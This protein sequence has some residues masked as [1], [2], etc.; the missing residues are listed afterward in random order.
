MNCVRPMNA[1]RNIYMHREGRQPIHTAIISLW[2]N[3]TR[4]N[5]AT[6]TRPQLKRQSTLTRPSMNANHTNKAPH[7]PNNNENALMRVWRS[8]NKA[9]TARPLLVKGTVACVIF[10]SSDVV[11][12]RYFTFTAD[13]SISSKKKKTA[14]N[15]AIDIDYK[16]A[17]SGAAFGWVGTVWLHYW[18]NFLE[19]VIQ[20]R[21]PVGRHRLANTLTKV[22]IDQSLAAPLY[23]YTYFFLTNFLQGISS[24]SSNGDMKNE[25]AHENDHILAMDLSTHNTDE[26]ENENATSTHNIPLSVYE[27]HRIA[28]EKLWPTMFVHWSVWPPVHVLNF[29]FNPIQHRILVQNISLVGWSGYLSHRNNTPTPSTESTTVTLSATLEKRPTAKATS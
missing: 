5:N 12:Q 1:A 22:V 29:Y 3:G 2:R 10:F 25:L 21:L 15:T 9:L 27:A 14:S 11:T 4:N 7:G 19:T 24:S 16:R 20:A 13:S 28:Y 26:E 23:I 6:I 8:Y 18:W 17:A